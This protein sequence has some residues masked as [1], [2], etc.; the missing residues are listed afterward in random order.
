MVK[1]NR[2][3]HLAVFVLGYVCV[4]VCV[5]VGG[6]MCVVFLF[7]SFV[8]CG[9]WEREGGGGGGGGDGVGKIDCNWRERH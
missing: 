5:C 6:L 4:C 1:T 7:C 9:G 8:D 2:H 3:A